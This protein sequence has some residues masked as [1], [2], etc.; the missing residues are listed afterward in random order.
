MYES[1]K[2]ICYLASK[3]HNDAIVLRVSEGL[4]GLIA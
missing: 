1:L 3:I 4:K 2:T